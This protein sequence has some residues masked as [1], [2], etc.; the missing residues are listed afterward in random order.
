VADFRRLCHAEAGRGPPRDDG[1]VDWECSERA[2]AHTEQLCKARFPVVAKFNKTKDGEVKRLGLRGHLLNNAFFRIGHTTALAIGAAIRFLARLVRIA[3]PVVGRTVRAAVHSDTTR[4]ASVVALVSALVGT[5][6]LPAY[7]FSPEIIAAAEL[8]QNLTTTGGAALAVE[9]STFRATSQERLERL[10]A[11]GQI[12]YPRYN[13]PSAADYLKNPA[14]PKFSL[15]KV[16]QVGKKYIGVPYRFGGSN[17]SGFDCSGFVMFVYSQFGV[18]LPHSAAAQGAM[19]K[20]IRLADARPGDIVMMDGHNGIYAGN[21][22]ILDAP[23]TGGAVSIRK[24]WTPD[25]YIVRL[26]I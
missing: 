26:G 9:Q 22:M 21:G 2:T 10:A 8:R 13:G 18:S 25:F 7:A 16:F 5:V 6:S 24:I 23:A 20:P 1:L 4:Q 3:R 19:G 14:Y 11:G 12:D 15:A 17:P